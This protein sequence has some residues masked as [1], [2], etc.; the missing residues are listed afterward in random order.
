MTILEERFMGQVPALLREISKSLSE[1]SE[2]L[3]KKKYKTFEDLV[4]KPRAKEEVDG[5]YKDCYQAKLDFGNGYI[6]S[7]LRGKQ[8]YS[9][10]VN[11]YEVAVI[12][13]KELVQLGD[14]TVAPYR[15]MKQVTEIMIEYQKK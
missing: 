1:I 4:F 10:G 8:F 15:T 2:A 14:D 9:D 5:F 11:T 3:G 12:H 13:G 7:V 6:V